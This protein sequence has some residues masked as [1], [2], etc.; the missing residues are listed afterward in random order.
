MALELLGP[1]PLPKRD[2]EE[3]ASTLS[4]SVGKLRN[5]TI[6]VTGATGFI[7]KWILSSFLYLNEKFELNCSLVA[8]TRNK[9]RFF[10]QF[11]KL[12]NRNEIVWIESDVRDFVLE[13]GTVIDYVFHAATDVVESQDS[14]ETFSTIVN[15]TEHLIDLC[16][17][18][19]A[20]T[21][22]NL[23]SG[24]VYGSSWGS[25]LLSESESTN[26][27]TDNLSSAYGEGKRVSELLFTI[28]AKEQVEN[29][30]V[31]NARCFAFVGPYLALDKQFA[32]GNFI[33]SALR[34]DEI[35]ISG[36]GTPLRSYLYS[37]DLVSCLWFLLLNC[38]GVETF[39]VGG[40]EIISI[41]DLAMRV[42][43]LSGNKGALKVH[44]E[45]NSNAKVSSY[46]P[47]TQSLRVKMKNKYAPI[48]LDEAL[49]RTL[50][51]YKA[52]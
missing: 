49:V 22:V 38:R 29:F 4:C 20:V 43:S 9:T 8:V 35:N 21:I 34:N 12:K 46:L 48:S 15:G 33:D 44:M 45:S 19:P 10:N 2:L 6:L 18:M 50:E 27:Q 13:P 36:D 40:D 24:A 41:K 1:I 5:K 7:G 39:N 42:N 3:I 47:N 25:Q 51:W 31:C 11:P 32:I 28:A 16:S 23:S 17:D 14:K 52:P 26:L 37:S 30:N